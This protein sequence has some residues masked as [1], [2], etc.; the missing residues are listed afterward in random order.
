MCRTSCW[1]RIMG[2]DAWWSV[3][4]AVLIGVPMYSNAAGIIPM[5][6]ALLGKGAALGT[7]LAFMMSVIG[8]V[9]ARDDHPAQGA[10]P[11]AD[12]GVH[13]CRGDGHPGGGI[14]VQRAV[15]L[16]RCAM[17]QVKVLGSGCKRCVATAAMIETEAAR[18][19]VSVTL[20]KV[21]DYAAIA[22][23]GAHGDAGRR[24]RRQ[25]GACRRAAARGRRLPLACPHDG[26]SDRASAV[27]C[28]RGN[29]RRLPRCRDG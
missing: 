21:T 19:G 10:K 18:L 20:E 14:S 29:A 11:A 27:R 3:P 8:A 6:E 7:V 5:V 4:A 13:R 2:S 28:R 1:P 22:G 25:A 23:Y 12:R 26:F 17:K 16:T 15:R 24:D 9:A